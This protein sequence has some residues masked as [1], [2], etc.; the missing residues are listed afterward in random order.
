MRPARQAPWPACPRATCPNSIAARIQEQQA[1]LVRKRDIILCV[2]AGKEVPTYLLADGLVTVPVEFPERK[3]WP[4]WY[5][6]VMLSSP[7]V[8]LIIFQHE[9]AFLVG[10]AIPMFFFLLINGDIQLTQSQPSDDDGTP[11]TYL[12][13]ELQELYHAEVARQAAE[14]NEFQQLHAELLK[15]RKST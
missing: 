14:P 9:I 7:V 2:A 1:N 6:G 5:W 11:A 8:M 13:G 10:M 4:L 15:Q 12:T 3:K